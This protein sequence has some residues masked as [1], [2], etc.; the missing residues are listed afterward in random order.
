MRGKIAFTIFSCLTAISIGI[1]QPGNSSIKLENQIPK[2]VTYDETII[3][4]RYGIQLY[5]PL[6]FQL[7]GDSVRNCEDG[8]ACQSWVEDFYA[9]GNLLH[10]GYYIDGQLKFYKNYF[11][12]GQL[13][14]EFK[15][16]DNVRCTMVKYY[17]NGQMK[18]KVKYVDGGAILWQDF[19][20]NGNPEFYEEYHKSFDYHI[21]RKS[22][23]EN[24]NPQSTLE[25]VNKKKLDFVKK[26]YYENGQVKIDGAVKYDRAG[27]DYYSTGKW[28]YYDENGNPTKEEYYT[29]G[30]VTKEKTF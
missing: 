2:K 25:M 1:A 8:Y 28:T 12:T 30:T 26:E 29:K 15:N 7:G 23:F 16:L 24:G 11:P 27:F 19:Y 22:Y 9:N 14:R 20:S 4:P 5:E 3:D 10:K 6:N 18:S 21:A 13:E 17:S